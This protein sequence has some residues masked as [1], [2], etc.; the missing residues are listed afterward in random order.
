MLQRVRMRGMLGQNVN[1]S[2]HVI[3][4]PTF[5]L[6]VKIINLFIVP[7]L[8]LLGL[9]GNSLI[10][11]VLCRHG[12]MSPTYILFTALTIADLSFMIFS[13][14]VTVCKNMGAYDLCRATM[15]NFMQY[16]F[17]FLY[18]LPGRISHFV[19]LM[20]GMERT[21]S[22]V[23]PMTVRSIWTRRSSL[24][25]IA[26]SVFVPT[27]LTWP[28]AIEYQVVRNGYAN[29]TSARY[30]SELTSI[31]SQFRQ[32]YANLRIAVLYIV[33][34]IPFVSILAMNIIIIIMLIK[35]ARNKLLTSTSGHK[36]VRI[37]RLLLS[38]GVFSC[39]C[40][41]PKVILQTYTSLDPE[42]QYPNY[43]NNLL[44]LF[45][46][47]GQTL[48][49]ANSALNFLM[50]TCAGSQFRKEFSETVRCRTMS[51]QADNSG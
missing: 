9:I 18:E 41:M 15:G 34:V 25:S 35:N 27:L 38:V 36:E 39:F 11:A 13:V 37:T 45:S 30:T 16:M 42:Y 32:S 50:Y 2:Y 33:Y 31:G 28:R 14:P 49:T 21:L 26:V 43:K 20:I 3:P 22:V 17:S 24:I 8:V 6:T 5:V 47:L 46:H 19:L 40:M 51:S 7:L 29:N 4:Q 48:I 10:L 23:I 12:K 44:A 1:G